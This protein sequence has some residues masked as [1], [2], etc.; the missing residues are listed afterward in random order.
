MYMGICFRCCFVEA[1]CAQRSEQT[2]PAAV[3]FTH[4]YHV[5]HGVENC[6]SVLVMPQTEFVIDVWLSGA[7]LTCPSYFNYFWMWLW[8][9]SGCVCLWLSI[10]FW[11]SLSE[12]RL[13]EWAVRSEVKES[14]K[15]VIPKSLRSSPDADAQQS[16]K[17]PFKSRRPTEKLLCGQ[18]NFFKYI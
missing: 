10:T 2:F 15:R 4:L 14:T 18:I 1:L 5:L 16:N 11:H 17:K 12:C 9:G 13:R 6:R 8:S 3:N 7:T